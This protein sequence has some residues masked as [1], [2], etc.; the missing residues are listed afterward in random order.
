MPLTIELTDAQLDAIAAAVA[1]K[2]ATQTRSD[3]A[4]YTIAEAADALGCSVETIRR[5]VRAGI[6]PTLPMSGSIKRI[7]AKA[8]FPD[9]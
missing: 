6:L 2:L 8:I 7:P 5:R 3:R 1:G 9:A 4:A